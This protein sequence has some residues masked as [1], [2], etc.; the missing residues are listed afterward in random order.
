MHILTQHTDARTKLIKLIKEVRGWRR[1]V[2]KKYGR[3]KKMVERETFTVPIYCSAFSPS[4]AFSPLS[5]PSVT[6]VCHVHPSC[7]SVTFVGPSITPKKFENLHY[8]CA[9][10]NP[11]VE[12]YFPNRAEC[13]VQ[14]KDDAQFSYPL[15]SALPLYTYIFAPTLT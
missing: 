1:G 4:H 9:N 5:R 12:P 10:G 8:M 7:P 13:K 11:R 3:A 2:G 14:K 15:C 6:S